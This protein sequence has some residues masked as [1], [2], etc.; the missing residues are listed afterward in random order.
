MWLVKL[1]IISTTQSRIQVARNTVNCII[2]LIFKVPLTCCQ[3]HLVKVE[4]SRRVWQYF[5]YFRKLI[6]SIVFPLYRLLVTKRIFLSA[7]LISNFET[8]LL[9]IC[10]EQ[11]ECIQR[12]L[13]C[14]VILLNFWKVY[15][16]GQKFYLR[17]KIGFQPPCSVL[18]Q[19]EREVVFLR[20][21]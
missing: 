17:R 11:R 7:L 3:D 5:N 2:K 4:N 6:T 10:Y 18:R 15:P 13:K 16:K 20:L 21:K 19:A 8:S 9:V 1:L 12:G 14:S